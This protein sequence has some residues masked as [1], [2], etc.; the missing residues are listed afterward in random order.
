MS[1]SAWTLTVLIVDIGLSVCAGDG[2]KRTAALSV[3]RAVLATAAANDT[4]V[5]LLLCGVR[6]KQNA[7]SLGG[8]HDVFYVSPADLARD[9]LDAQPPFQ[10][11]SKSVADGL[12]QI[13]HDVGVTVKSD[14][15]SALGV[16]LQDVEEAAQALLL[17]PHD[18]RRA[19]DV[20]VIIVSD[21]AST[22]PRSSL[23]ANLGKV[24]KMCGEFGVVIELCVI[25]DDD[26]ELDAIERDA[27]LGRGAHSTADEDAGG[28]GGASVGA[29]A[30]L[31]AGGG[32]ACQESFSGNLRGGAPENKAGGWGAASP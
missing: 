6:S 17:P 11:P 12:I 25:H 22:V 19:G 1:L 14:I 15:W 4:R 9:A 28:G 5:A 32:G 31:A 18:A 3:A 29:G 26:G 8:V 24:A 20:R 30:G 16:A 21:F 27:L 7:L 23:G 13:A 2:R 10:I